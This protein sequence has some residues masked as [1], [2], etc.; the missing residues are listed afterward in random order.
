MVMFFLRATSCWTVFRAI[1][2]LRGCPYVLLDKLQNRSL[3]EMNARMFTVVSSVAK[4]NKLRFCSLS[5]EI[6]MYPWAENCSAICNEMIRYLRNS[7]ADLLV[8]WVAQHELALFGGATSF[9]SFLPLLFVWNRIGQ[10]LFA[11]QI[12]HIAVCFTNRLQILLF[13]NES[14]KR[15]NT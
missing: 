15:E 12:T 2:L 8:A 11:P 3:F 10:G 13:G 6:S 9:Y 7:L 5:R 4:T 1:Y 14:K